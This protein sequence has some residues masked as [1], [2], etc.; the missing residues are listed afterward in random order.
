MLSLADVTEYG[1]IMLNAYIDEWGRRRIDSLL[2]DG[3]K[4]IVTIGII[5]KQ[6]SQIGVTSH[7]YSRPYRS[8]KLMQTANT[9]HVFTRP[10]R[11]LRLIQILQILHAWNVEYPS[12]ILK[13]WFAALQATH[14]FN[15]PT[16][17]MGLP[18]ILGLNHIF[19]RPS[20]MFSL[21]DKLELFHE[22]RVGKPSTKRTK[23]FLVLGELAIQLSSD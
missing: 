1:D 2:E 5:L 8:M 10:F 22:F 12:L 16:R 6:W 20:Q 4:I 11:S 7:V 18:A 15:R 14:A 13:Q 19:S 17:V 21:F 3:T 23:L 9:V